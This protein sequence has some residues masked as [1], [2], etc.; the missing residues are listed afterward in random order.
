MDDILLHSFVQLG[1]ER[2]Q[3]LLGFIP[4]LR[5]HHF[6][7]LACDGFEFRAYDEVIRVASLVDADFL[8]R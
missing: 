1:E 4:L 8:D 6:A 2:T 3:S 5:R 7:D